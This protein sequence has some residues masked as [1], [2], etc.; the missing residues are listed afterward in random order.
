MIT[1]VRTCVAL[2][3]DPIFIYWSGVQ[4]PK[5]AYQLELVVSFY[6]YLGSKTKMLQRNVQNQFQGESLFLVWTHAFPTS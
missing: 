1:A 5:P 3:W 4:A 2:Q 6:Y